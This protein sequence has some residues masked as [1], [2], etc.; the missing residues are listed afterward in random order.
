MKNAKI[1]QLL[2][3]DNGTTKDWQTSVYLTSNTGINSTSPDFT[4]AGIRFRKSRDTDTQPRLSLVGVNNDKIRITFVLSDLSNFLLGGKYAL[5]FNNQI[6]CTEDKQ[7]PLPLSTDDIANDMKDAI[8]DNM[9]WLD[10]T[11]VISNWAF[12]YSD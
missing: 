8:K 10:G 3:K 9:K 12:A 4:F 11:A 6:L 7:R 5:T 1:D 2:W